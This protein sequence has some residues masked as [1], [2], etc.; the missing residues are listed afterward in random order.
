MTSANIQSIGQSSQQKEAQL[1][2]RRRYQRG[3]LK[4]K[5]DR[6]IGRW[7]EDV[8]ENGVTRRQERS[9]F[10]GYKE[11]LPTKRLAQRALDQHLSDINSPQ[12]RA[13]PAATFKEFATKWQDNVAVHYKPSTRATTDSIIRTLILPSLGETKLRD[14]SAEVLQNQFISS[15]KVTP[16]T[17]RNAVSVAKRMWKSAKAWGYVEHNPFDGLELPKL[18]LPNR[19]YFT[20]D[21]MRRIIDA[22]DEP[23][24]TLY[25]L[26]AETGL[27]AGELAGL[28]WEDIDDDKRELQVRQSI[29]HGAVQ[30]PKSRAGTRTVSISASLAGQLAGVR[31]RAGGVLLPY[32]FGASDGGPINIHNVKR[33]KL[34]PLLRRLGIQRAGFHAFRHGNATILVSGGADARSVA[35]RL[36]H[37]D[38]A[39]TLRVY[40]HALQARDREMADELGGILRTEEAHG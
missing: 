10:I 20:A 13:R 25:W 17:V 28:R 1:L 7:R 4:L 3:S 32:V 37:S 36:G 19:R 27:R 22:A 40:A 8:I 24:K 11:D 33:Q 31:Q 26:A 35:T 15:L 21:E 34:Q 2:A 6:W 39:M 30:S 23:E 16:K 5:G 38:P 9:S 29:W 18:Q 14:V 12:Y